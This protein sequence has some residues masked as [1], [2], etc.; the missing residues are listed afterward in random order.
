MKVRDLKK[1]YVGRFKPQRKLVVTFTVRQTPEM[2]RLMQEW[3]KGVKDWVNTVPQVEVTKL[4][5]PKCRNR[6]ELAIA[7]MYG[8][9][10]PEKSAEIYPISL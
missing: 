5:L 2:H 9:P 3:V 4:P 1:R 6:H 10:R 8:L 7:K